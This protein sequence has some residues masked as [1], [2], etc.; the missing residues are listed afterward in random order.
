MSSVQVHT[1]TIT[2][3]ERP[4]PIEGPRVTGLQIKEA[5]IAAGLPISVDFMLT[6]ELANGRSKVVGDADVVT[7]NKNSRF[8]AV[9]G[10]DNS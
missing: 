7:V 8:D 5:A 1:V 10:D 2:I 9:A 6:E 3:N 4:V